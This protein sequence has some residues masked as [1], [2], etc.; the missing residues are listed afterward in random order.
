M[1]LDVKSLAFGAVGERQE[2]ELGEKKF[3]LADDLVAKDLKGKIELTRLDDSILA[4]VSG[5]A[6]IG[7]E[8]DRC[9]EPYLETVQF[10]L[11][12]EYHLGGY[13]EDEEDLLVSRDF[14]I[15]VTEPLRE[16]IILAPPVRKLC[17]KDCKG[18]CSH[19]GTNLNAGKC[20]CS[21]A[22]N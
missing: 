14:K 19:C 12:L 5:N 2:S 9:L 1:H 8:C 11:S 18:L 17:R 20:K 4:Q 22:S 10:D 21:K 3:L 16:E 13:R 15:D 7:L 6:D